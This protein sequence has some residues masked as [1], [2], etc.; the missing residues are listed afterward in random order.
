[1][2][3]VNLVLLLLFTSDDHSHYL[4]Y[5]ENSKNGVYVESI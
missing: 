5:L 2:F 1:M 3:T 4:F